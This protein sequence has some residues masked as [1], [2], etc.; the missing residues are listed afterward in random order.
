MPWPIGVCGGQVWR[1]L[2]TVAGVLNRHTVKCVDFKALEKVQTVTFAVTTVTDRNILE[3]DRAGAAGL[4]GR[5]TK[6]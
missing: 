4:C 3:F 1:H 6:K 2:D 5:G